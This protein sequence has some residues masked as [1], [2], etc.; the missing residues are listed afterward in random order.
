MQCLQKNH[1]GEHLV[2]LAPKMLLICM[3]KKE[4]TFCHGG[5]YHSEIHKKGLQ[6]LAKGFLKCYL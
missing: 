1:S 4:W 6:E 3:D 2:P 5:N